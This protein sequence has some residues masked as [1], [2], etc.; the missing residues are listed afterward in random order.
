MSY[1][2]PQYGQPLS[3]EE[4]EV[5]TAVARGL[6]NVQVSAQLY[7]SQSV[8]KAHIKRM[9]IKLGANNRRPNLVACG[10]VTGY[11]RRESLTVGGAR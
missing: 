1:P 8:I 6:T 7:M 3:R 11:L 4:I 9:S 10:F 5:L 2:L